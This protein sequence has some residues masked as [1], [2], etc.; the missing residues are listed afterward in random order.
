MES[1]WAQL[2]RDPH[3]KRLLR[4][5]LSTES[6]SLLIRRPFDLAHDSRT[7]TLKV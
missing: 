3:L 6:G 1:L 2:A 5:L 7:F 4:Y